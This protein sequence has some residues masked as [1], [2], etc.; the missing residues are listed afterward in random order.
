MRSLRWQLTASLGSLTLAQVD[1]ATCCAEVENLRVELFVIARD[2]F[3]NQSVYLII[4]KSNSSSSNS[5]NY[6][7]SAQSN[8]ERGPCRCESLHV[9]RTVPIGYNGAPQIRP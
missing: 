7:K 5:N 6:N 4:N 9:R 8:L 3:F 2:N 1:T